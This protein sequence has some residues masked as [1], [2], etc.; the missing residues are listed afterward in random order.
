MERLLSSLDHTDWP[1]MFQHLAR[2][3]QTMA[4]A[5]HGIG[6]WRMPRA[7]SSGEAAAPEAASVLHVHVVNAHEIGN[8]TGDAVHRGL[9][10]PAAIAPS[11]PA[12]ATMPWAPGLLP[13]IP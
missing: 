11:L 13:A 5:G 3:L 12:P 8:A 7:V 6:D 4:K 10:M 9:R 1:G 2:G